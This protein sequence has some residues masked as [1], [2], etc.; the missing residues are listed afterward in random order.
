MAL[1]PCSSGSRKYSTE[2]PLY[3]TPEIRGLRTLKCA[4]SE[5]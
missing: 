2:M 1:I 5:G 4:D 3:A